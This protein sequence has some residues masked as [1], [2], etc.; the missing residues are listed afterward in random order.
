MFQSQAVEV[1]GL[2]RVIARRRGIVLISVAAF[3]VLAIALNA[4]TSPV[5]RTAA[6]LEIQ[7][8]PSRS[9][10]TGAEVENPTP[11]S[12]NLALLTT[13]ERILSRDVLER[14]AREL[15]SHGV[16]LDPGPPPIVAV[17]PR[18]RARA[19]AATFRVAGSTPAPLVNGVASPEQRLAADVEWLERAVSVRPIRDTRL[20]DV[21]AEHSDPRAA[22]EVANV[23]AAQ[24]VRGEA[25]HRRDAEDERLGALR[26]QASDVRGA[27]QASEHALYG[28]QNAGLAL[29]GARAKQLAEAGA[30]LGSSLIKANADL[31]GL[32]AQLDR[33]R[34][35]RTAAQPDWS[36]PPVQTPAMDDLHREL[37]RTETEILAQRRVYRDG[38]AE[39]VSLESQASALRDAMRRE[40]EKAF[41]DLV[42]QR[43]GMEARVADLESARSHNDQAIQALSD[44]STKYATMESELSTQRDLYT[45]LLK[46]IQEQDV[47][48]LIQTPS[49]EVAQAAVV[50]LRSVRP[51][52]AVNLG[53]GVLLGLV[54]GAGLALA[55][56]AFRRTLCTPRDVAEQLGL[57]VM[58]MIPRRR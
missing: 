19:G 18:L 17:G 54:F 12:E 21:Q 1:R 27:L 57:Q 37:Q 49:V 10:L 56:E 28:S 30:E 42:G 33:I 25:E 4:L 6:R 39:L 24:F 2:G 41:S 9:P 38:S 47:A 20:V 13:A 53:V 50:P 7:P 16:T 48:Q 31:H 29:A 22:A 14:S 51:R 8:T 46:K 52:K 44:S 36:N 11:A 32:A 35:F 15:E 55:L 58:G 34:E 3:V 40:L 45:L 43:E 23:V 5:Y 26:D